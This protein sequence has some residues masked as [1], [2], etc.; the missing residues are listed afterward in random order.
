MKSEELLKLRYEVIGAAPLLRNKIGEIIMCNN[1]SGRIECDFV[2][3]GKVD[4]SPDSYPLIFRKMNWWEKRSIEEM[5]KKLQSLS[6]PDEKPY[7]IVKWDM[8]NLIGLINIKTRECCDLT[9][10][11][12]EYSYIPVD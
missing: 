3:Q 2:F 11:K 1:P 9:L 8:E 12:P 6:F 7:E 4:I 5:P 10:M